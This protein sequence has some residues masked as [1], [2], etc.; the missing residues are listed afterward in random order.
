MTLIPLNSYVAQ[1]QAYNYRDC[2]VQFTVIQTDDLPY[3]GTFAGIFPAAI[4]QSYPRGVNLR[5]FEVISRSVFE[6]CSRANES[7]QWTGDRLGNLK[8]VTCAIVHWKMASQKSRTSR[9]VENVRAKWAQDAHVQLLDAYRESSLKKFRIGGVR[10][11]TATAFL[12]FLYPNDYGIMDKHVVNDFTQK[13]GITTLSLRTEDGYISDLSVNINKYY[14]EYVP[15]LQAEAAALN[16]ARLTFNDV[17]AA[18]ENIESKFR[19]CDI[20]MA[21]FNSR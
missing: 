14:T 3:V 17:D 15:F 10:I 7:G 6:D 11:P 18:G 8:S 2:E 21:L 5:K 4:P 9:S 16:N 1:R 13:N 19:P 12:R 20:E